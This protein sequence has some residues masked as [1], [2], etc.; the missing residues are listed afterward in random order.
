MA[1]SSRSAFTLL[2]TL[3]A[4]AIA[5]VVVGLVYSVFHSVQSTVELQQSLVSGPERG[6]AALGVISD[7]LARAFVGASDPETRFRLERK[8]GQS[9]S[10][11]LHFCT[12]RADAMEQDVRWADAIRV[13]FE[14]V[15]GAEGVTLIQTERPLVG[16]GSLSEP[17]T[18]ALAHRVSDW[19]AEVFD[20]TTWRNEWP[21][22]D[23]P[24]LLPRAV[25]VSFQDIRGQRRETEVFIGAQ[26]STTSSLQRAVADS[27]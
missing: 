13:G 5:F 10:A 23:K 22:E 8:S 2:E 18:N 14:T 20:G 12:L 16:P 21:T 27:P 3:L 24:D 4:L 9:E 7:D 15:A 6:V 25:R 26:T 17:T 19:A 11:K 1:E